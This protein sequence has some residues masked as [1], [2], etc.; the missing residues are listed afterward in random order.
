MLQA[1]TFDPNYQTLAAVNQDIF[2][3]DKK[4]DGGGGG[5]ALPNIRAPEG[6]P[7]KVRA[8]CV[9][10]TP[11]SYTFHASSCK[12]K[13]GLLNFSICRVTKKMQESVKL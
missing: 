2:G 12:K 8:V 7:K 3:A 6:P 5:G 13:G 10:F 11:L 4:A 1:D 9:V